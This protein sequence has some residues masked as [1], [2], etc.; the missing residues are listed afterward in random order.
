VSAWIVT[1]FRHGVSATEAALVEA[2]TPEAAAV[3]AAEVL[4]AE[5]RDRAH[6]GDGEP[7]V[8]NVF[9]A[10]WDPVVFT[11]TPTFTVERS[12]MQCCGGPAPSYVR[13]GGHYATCPLAPE[14]D[15][16]AADVADDDVPAE[17]A[18]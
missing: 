13:R 18:A 4:A 12:E 9:V 17:V 16:D 10:P 2:D 15:D 7:E 8:D 3:E 6:P 14:R 1:L 11:T 5:W